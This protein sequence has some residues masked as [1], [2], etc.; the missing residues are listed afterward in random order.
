MSES[1]LPF[2]ADSEIFRAFQ[3]LWR[4]EIGEELT[5][6]YAESNPNLLALVGAV[7]RWKRSGNA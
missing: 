2:Q 5:Y 7:A 4:E 3:Q 1:V 6:E